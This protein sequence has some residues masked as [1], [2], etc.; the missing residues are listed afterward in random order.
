MV[1][2]T[3]LST[4]R[5]GFSTPAGDTRAFADALER[6]AI[7]AAFRQDLGKAGRE[8]VKGRYGRERLADDIDHLYRSLLAARVP[9]IR[10]GAKSLTDVLP[11][12][13]PVHTPPVISRRAASRLRVILLSQ[14]FPP[15]VGATQS[16]MQSFAEHL[17]DRGHEVTVICELPNHPHGQIPPRY[18]GVLVEDDRSNPYRVLRVRVLAHREDAGDAHA[19]LPLV[20]GNGGRDRT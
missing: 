17:A 16:R 11:R 14:Y 12:T 8:R 3:S 1:R 5:R 18:D 10:E 15:E 9:R 7:D 2:P 19:V 4:A 20:H 13:L 6:L